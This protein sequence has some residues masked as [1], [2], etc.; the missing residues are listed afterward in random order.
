MR[1]ALAVGTL[2]LLLGCSGAPATVTAPDLQCGQDRTTDAAKD[3]VEKV[4]GLRTD[5]VVVRLA[6]STPAGIVALVD[7]DVERAY[8]LL[9]DRYGVAVVAQAEGDGV[10]DG[11]AQIERL[12][13]S[14]CPQG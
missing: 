13:R 6:R 7:G 8:R 5:D 1:R 9:H 2:V 3:V 11:L 14:S 12:V 4:G 10:A